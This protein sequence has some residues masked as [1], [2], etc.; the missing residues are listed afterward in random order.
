VSDLLA[1]AGGTG[2]T[3][4]DMTEDFYNRYRAGTEEDEHSPTVV[5][6]GGRLEDDTF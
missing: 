5:R 2:T 1:T 6:S 4:D 3:V